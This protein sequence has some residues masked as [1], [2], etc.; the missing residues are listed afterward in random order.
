MAVPTSGKLSFLSVYG[1]AG[2]VE[3]APDR[4]TTRKEIDPLLPIILQHGQHTNLMHPAKSNNELD[5]RRTFSS[6]TPLLKY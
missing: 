1:H 6:H 2:H 5:I 4:E 3:T